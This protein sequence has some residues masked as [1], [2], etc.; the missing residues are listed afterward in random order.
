M[1]DVQ[2]FCARGFE[3]VKDAFAQNFENGGEIG[4]SFSAI[5][6]GEIVV[7]IWGGF[8]D[9]AKT[10]PWADNTLTLMFSTT[11]GVSAIVAAWLVDQ[12]V[13]DFET[14]VSHY[15]PDFGAHGKDK[16]TLGQML[17]HQAGVPGFPDPIDPDLWLDPPKLAAAIASVAPLWPPGT[18]SGYHP[19]TWG[20]IIGETVQR[21]AKRSLGTILR[22]KICKPL[23]IDFHIGLDDADF[24][25]V[26]EM[27]KPSQ[28]ANFGE[29]TPMVR[30]AFMTKWAAPQRGG[31]E[32]KRI[33]VPSANGHATARA[34]ARL[35]EIYAT[36]GEI[37]G[38]RVLS[39]QAFA[40]LTQARI[41]GQDLVLPFKL[42][43]RSG[44]MANSLK[45]F[46]PNG[47]AFG[48]SGS[49]GSCGFGDPKAKVAAAYVMNKQSHHLIGDPRA[50]S[51]IGALYAS[52]GA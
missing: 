6:Q 37:L 22:D 51:L 18:A 11:K 9:K 31:D 17:S 32:W 39:E 29:I 45:F 15:W 20:Y 5:H 43:W 3:R 13:L 46:G 21:A 28:V 7:D 27:R 19:L 30:A 26:S 38:K 48:H 23:G 35:Y 42:D 8:S 24:G 36:G 16:L 52:L 2:G 40:G 47:E 1:V 49:G 14:P 41:S 4:A 10:K 33:E 12:G 50:T 25:R 34:V 44:V